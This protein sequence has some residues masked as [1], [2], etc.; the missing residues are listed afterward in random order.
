V[1]SA[2]ANLHRCNPVVTVQKD[3]AE[4]AVMVAR[5]LSSSKLILVCQ[6]ALEQCSSCVG[7]AKQSVPLH[8]ARLV[9]VY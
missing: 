7:Y 5:M 3:V 8:H 6:L 1:G 4:L 9:V 2:V